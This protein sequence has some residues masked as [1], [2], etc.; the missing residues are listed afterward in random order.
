[1]RVRNR[2]RKVLAWGSAVL[3]ASLC[4]GLWFAY[5]YVTDSDTLARRSRAWQADADGNGGVHPRAREVS[6]RVLK[7]MRS[8]ARP[9]LRGAGMP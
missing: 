4:G 6:H 7:R 2:L 8:T 9:A 5:V 3:L 1:M